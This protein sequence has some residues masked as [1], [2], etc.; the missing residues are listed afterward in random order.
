MI[1]SYVV[2]KECEVGKVGQVVFLNNKVAQPLVADHT[3]LQPGKS[4]A[5][6]LPPNFETK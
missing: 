6:G 2:M 3:L 1:N 4:G 5:S